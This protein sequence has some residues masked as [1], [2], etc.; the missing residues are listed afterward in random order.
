MSEVVLSHIESLVEK[1]NYKKLP[2][3]LSGLSR[4][5]YEQHI[6][7]LDK[8]KPLYDHQDRILSKG[9]TRIVIGD[10]G[11]YVEI[12]PDQ[13]IRDAL[14]IPKEQEFRLNG[15]FYGKYV[16][17]TSDG[18]NKIY[19]QIR[20]VNYADYLINCYYISPYEVKQ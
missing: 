19:H 8:S 2:K 15:D 1:Y 11:P 17:Y 20:T 12:S 7:I 10:Y 4:I 5:L 3:T 13:I 6:P 16:W 18:V 14:W 9:F